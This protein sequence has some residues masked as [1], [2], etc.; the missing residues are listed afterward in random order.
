MIDIVLK[1]DK[2]I[3]R[4][5][6]EDIY[7]GE[8]KIS[9]INVY[10]PET[11]NDIDIKDYNIVLR[12]YINADNYIPYTLDTTKSINKIDITHEFTD[13]DRYIDAYLYI[14]RADEVIGKTN[15]ISFRV[16]KAK[17]GSGLT[18]R[19]MKQS[20]NRPNR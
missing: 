18:P 16:N 13:K 14:T 10:L 5:K 2:T 9:W 3:R 20:L 6:H 15:T 17:D 19:E 4:T 12:C 7:E 8:N 1:K 11:I